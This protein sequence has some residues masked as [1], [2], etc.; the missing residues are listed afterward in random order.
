MVKLYHADIFET[1]EFG[2]M[3]KSSTFVLLLF[4]N[5]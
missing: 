4:F 1:R 2:G 5:I 3:T